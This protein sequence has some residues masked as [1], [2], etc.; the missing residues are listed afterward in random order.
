MS[1]KT[2]QILETQHRRLTC[3]G[4]AIASKLVGPPPTSAASKAPP[5]HPP[6]PRSCTRTSTAGPPRASPSSARAHG[7]AESRT[8]E[9]GPGV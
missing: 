1:L 7:L 9:E 4:T 6:P 5:H 2:L 8:D 3:W